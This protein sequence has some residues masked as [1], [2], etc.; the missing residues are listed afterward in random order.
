MIH[1][2]P[3]LKLAQVHKIGDQRSRFNY[4]PI[5]SHPHDIKSTINTRPSER[6]RLLLILPEHARS[7]GPG[8]VSYPRP[9]DD[10]GKQDSRGGEPWPAKLI[11]I[12]PRPFSNSAKF[13]DVED[14]MR[15][16]VHLLPRIDDSSTLATVRLGSAEETERR[17]EIH[18]DVGPRAPGFLPE[19]NP[20]VRP[21]A[22]NRFT[23]AKRRCRR[24]S[25]AATP[26]SLNSL[27]LLS[28]F[29]TAYDGWSPTGL[30]GWWGGAGLSNL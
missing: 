7:N 18:I 5:S 3:R 24:E 25:Q 11:P 26:T 15:T 4:S 8:H 30:F 14:I 23:G 27:S 9:N 22:Q 19:H 21:S 20:R 10:G 12:L 28:L 2:Q 6:V 17:W 16:R 29:F 13:P 1:Q